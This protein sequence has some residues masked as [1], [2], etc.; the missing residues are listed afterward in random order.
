MNEIVYTI[1]IQSV[2]Q[3]EWVITKNLQEIAD[4]VKFLKKTYSTFDFIGHGI[5]LTVNPPKNSAEEIQFYFENVLKFEVQQ[6]I[7]K[8]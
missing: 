4:F 3:F 8:L 5:S 2:E 1:E 6:L 7:E